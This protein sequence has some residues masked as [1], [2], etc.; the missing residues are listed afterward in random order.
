MR[1]LSLGAA[2]VV[3]APGLGFAQDTATVQDIVGFLVTNQGVQTNDFDRDRAAADATR[4]TLTRALLAAIA[5]VP[6]SSS[7]GGFV[8]RLNPALGTVERASD[9]FGPFFVE[10]ALTSGRGQASI[11]FTFQYASFESLDG[12]DLADGSFITTANQFTDE[13]EPFDI[14]RLTLQLSTRTATF[15]GNVGLTDRID[16]GG[17][18]PLVRLDVRGSRVNSYRG[19]DLLQAR[20]EANTYGLGDIAVRTKVRLTGDTPG[21]VAA[22]VEVRLP[23]GREE[24][25]LGAGETALRFLGMASAETGPANVYGN[26]AFGVGGIGREISY[27]GALAVAATNRVTIVGEILARH[28]EG[29]QRVTAVAEPHPRIRNVSTVRLLP[30]GEEETSVFAVTGVKVNV[31]STWLLHAHVLI[32]LSD[33][34]LTAKVTPTIALDYSFTR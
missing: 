8:Y 20:A 22:G 32:P 2:L 17:V 21:A 10:R 31:G 14:E 13:P 25:L 16:I 12:N 18:V 4:S 27:S 7:S 29:M 9:T 5:T 28:L 19:S 3:G 24:D 33:S 30:A 23:T 11:G 26:V 34:G 15:F 1:R 6:V